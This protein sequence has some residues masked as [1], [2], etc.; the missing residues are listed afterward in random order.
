MITIL[1]NLWFS[2]FCVRKLLLSAA[3]SSCF[4]GANLYPRNF[5]FSHGIVRMYETDF[6]VC[7]LVVLQRVLLPALST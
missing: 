4:R 7:L 5:L 1:L 3:F 6:F 2:I